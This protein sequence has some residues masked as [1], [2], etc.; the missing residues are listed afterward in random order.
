MWHEIPLETQ[1]SQSVAIFKSK[2]KTS[3][4]AGLQFVLTFDIFYIFHILSFDR[5]NIF[6][7]YF[8]KAPLKYFNL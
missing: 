6:I 3:V 4:Q 8:G 1:N 2:L 7:E 5:F